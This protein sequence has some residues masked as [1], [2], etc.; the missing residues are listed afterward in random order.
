MVIGLDK[1]AAEY[2]KQ[3]IAAVLAHRGELPQPLAV[4][5]IY[6]VEQTAAM[7]IRGFRDGNY[8]YTGRAIKNTCKALG[9]KHTR[10]AME[11]YFN[12]TF[13]E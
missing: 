9:I 5:L 6:H 8:N 11:T 1:F 3:L 13:T 10:T 7:M 4:D 12:Q 2:R